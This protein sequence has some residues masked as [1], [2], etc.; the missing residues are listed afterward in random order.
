MVELS[1]PTYVTPTEAA[2]W[3]NL[4]LI[5]AIGGLGV[6]ALT[7]LIKNKQKVPVSEITKWT[8]IFGVAAAVSIWDI[9]R[10]SK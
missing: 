4:F 5:G 6:I 9:N 10:S 2:S 3:Y 7:E 8:L 1:L